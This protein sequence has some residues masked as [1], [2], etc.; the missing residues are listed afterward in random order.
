MP[1]IAEIQDRL[2]LAFP[3][4]SNAPL[5]RAVQEGS[6][7]ADHLFEGETFLKNAIGRDIR[8][9]I[10]RVG[11]CHQIQSYCDPGD[12]TFVATMQPMPRGNWH[13]LEI[14]STGALAHVCR[15]EDVEKFPVETDS[16]QDFR[17]RLQTDLL[18]W[19][20]EDRDLRKLIK[21][22]PKLYAWLTFRVAQDGKVSH[23]CWAAPAVDIDEYIAH[24]NVLKSIEKSGKTA[25]EVSTV[26]DPAAAVRL[27]DHIVKA[28][29]RPD[30]DKTAGG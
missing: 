19:R 30:S 17:L 6:Y 25:P 10:R 3:P 11:I 9:H 18:N 12:L 22:I 23:L 4:S 14:L 7:L 24:I 15:T 20:D 13:W 8:G 26:P 2:S 29:E 21:E 1:I 27:K 28:L 16:R 5:L